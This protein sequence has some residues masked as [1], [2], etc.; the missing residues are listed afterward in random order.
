VNA[1][2]E[3][4]TSVVG[5]SDLETNE[6]L[7]TSTRPEG[8]GEQPTYETTSTANP[9][10]NPTPPK[11]SRFY[12]PTVGVLSAVGG[13]AAGELWSGVFGGAS[14]VIAVGD[15]V[16]DEA[17]HWLKQFAVDTF[18][19]N[20]KTALVVGILA[21]TMI[22]AALVGRSAAKKFSSGVVG[23]LG[24]AVVGFVAALGG[25]TPAFRDV[26]PITF[27][28]VTVIG[29]LALFLKRP[30]AKA[31]VALGAVD[32][33]RFI[34]LSSLTTLGAVAVGGLGRKLQGNPEAE[35]ARE[36]IVL[37]N[38]TVVGAETA[39]VKAGENG[40]VDRFAP[41][42]ATPFYVPTGEY[43]RIDTALA[44]P[45]INSDT[46][47]MTISG[48]VNKPITLTYKDLLARPLIEH[49]CTLMCVSNEIG[50][51]L[52]GNARWTGV[53]LADVLREAGVQPEAD[54]VFVTSAEGFTAGFPVEAAL[55]GREA[56]IAIAMNGEPLPFK[57]GFP[58]RLVI[59]GIYG[60]VS[61]VKWLQ[62]IKLTTFEL[63]QGYWVPRGWSALGPI[64]TGSRIDVPSSRNP[65]KVGKTPI[66][67][68]AWDQHTGIEMV[69]VQVDD[70]PW[71]KAE[72][73][74]AGRS[75]RGNNGNWNGMQRR[76]TTPFGSGPPTPTVSRK[77][78]NAL[79]L[80]LTVPPDGTRSTY[81]CN[82]FLF[83]PL[84]G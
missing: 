65:A 67:G 29:L 80:I 9:T 56:L 75:T 62:D 3:Y 10:P 17:P 42:G 20:N 38:A 72:L 28:A 78:N 1:D 44:I 43:Y 37:P 53:R 40:F 74:K 69:E 81:P 77:Q 36:R 30:V 61:A 46:W 52:I 39:P 58:A 16:V 47:S 82:T 55:D 25:R 45:R 71:R 70:G 66:A 23:V 60:Y 15:R 24:F 12:A 5:A 32:R 49:D 68:I 31:G 57:H 6:A 11:R 21:I 4:M 73:A 54:Q 48:L 59:P 41:P 35:A 7:R 19:T 83:T 13:L 63:D 22:Y 8:S 50:G 14:P 18:G 51:N 27:A 79:A 84:A 64:K 76:A 33:R 34:T 26:L 2:D